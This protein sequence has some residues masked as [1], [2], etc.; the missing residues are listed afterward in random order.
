M[1]HTSCIIVT[2]G[3]CYYASSYIYHCKNLGLIQPKLGC[4]SCSLVSSCS[5]SCMIILLTC[6]TY[7]S[8]YSVTQVRMWPFA[9]KAHTMQ[10]QIHEYCTLSSNNTMN[11]WL[12]NNVIIWILQTDGTHLQKKQRKLLHFVRISN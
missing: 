1:I 3:H 2:V 8:H 9:I 11:I 10:Q 4:L 12:T 5:L 6:V 7:K